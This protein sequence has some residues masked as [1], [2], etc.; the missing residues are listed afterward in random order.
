MGGSEREE[1]ESGSGRESKPVLW[2]P[3]VHFLSSPFQFDT[4][5]SLARSQ[6]RQVAEEMKKTKVMKETFFFFLATKNNF[7]MFLFL[8]SV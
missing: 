2:R 7:T 1:R 8:Q 6:N 3:I 4:S 5:V